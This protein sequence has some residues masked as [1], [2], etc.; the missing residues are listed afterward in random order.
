MTRVLPVGVLISGEGTTL[1]ALAETIAGGH[2]PA[3]ISVVVADRPHAPGVERARRR[4]LPTAVIPFR[5]TSE[6][7]WSRRV[8]RSLRDTGVELVALAGFLA[9]I[10][11][12]LLARWAGRMIN[13]HPSFLPKYGGRGMFGLRVHEAV[14]AARDPETGATVHLVTDALDGGPTLLQER[15]PVEP[16]DTAESLRDRVRPVER[17]L[18]FDAIRHF[19]DGDW[20]LPFTSP[21]ERSP[22]R[23][24]RGA[25][26]S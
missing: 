13:V 5:G 4:G 8:D 12:R 23:E 2:L 16:N 17:R 26:G 22:S 25:R 1:D 21:E 19:A 20:P 9:V 10:P 3:R 11:P 14:L 6:E 18:L 15:V 7:E 24:P